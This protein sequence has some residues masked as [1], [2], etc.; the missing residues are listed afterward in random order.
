MGAN[1]GGVS[2]CRLLASSARHHLAIISPA[3]ISS[4]MMTRAA[5]KRADQ[6]LWSSLTLSILMALVVVCTVALQVGASVPTAQRTPR[7]LA[8]SLALSV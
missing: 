8:R 1:V 4:S 5:L 6:R 7:S 2:R 3:T